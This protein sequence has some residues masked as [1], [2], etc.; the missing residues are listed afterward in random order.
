MEGMAA[1]GDGA[2]QALAALLEQRTRRQLHKLT[3]LLLLLPYVQVTWK[4]W[5]PSHCSLICAKTAA[6]HKLRAFLVPVFSLAGDMEGMAAAGDGASQALAALMEQQPLLEVVV[7]F[8]EALLRQQISGK[9]TLIS[10]LV[11]VI[12]VG[13]LVA[14]FV[15]GVGSSVA[16]SC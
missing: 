14:C 10:R 9:N 12:Q 7:R 11:A 5:Q 13:L 16:S 4:A 6:T 1:A 3:L 15:F 2:S 8:N